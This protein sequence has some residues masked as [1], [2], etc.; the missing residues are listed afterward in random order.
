MTSYV[1]VSRT[2]K[3]KGVGWFISRLVYR[4]AFV[5]YQEYR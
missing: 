4:L 2:K 3:M 5:L 1:N